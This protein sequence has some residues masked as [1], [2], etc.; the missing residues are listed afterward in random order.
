LT[1]AISSNPGPIAISNPNPI[2]DLSG[3]GALLNATRNK[4]R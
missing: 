1:I 2:E 3:P 4:Q